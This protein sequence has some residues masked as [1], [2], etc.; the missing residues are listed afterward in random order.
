MPADLSGAHGALSTHFDIDIQ[1]T[2]YIRYSTFS[3]QHYH[4]RSSRDSFLGDS[5]SCPQR[6]PSAHQPEM[7]TLSNYY[8]LIVYRPHDNKLNAL[9][10][11]S[12]GGG[13]S[14]TKLLR[15]RTARV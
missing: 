14:I 11:E 5:V 10:V 3:E 6:L 15:H 1:P 12:S 7:N 13:F 2:L 9:K 4:Q 8:T